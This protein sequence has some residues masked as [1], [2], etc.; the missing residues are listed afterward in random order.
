MDK[1]MKETCIEGVTNHDNPESCVC[2]R[3]A[4]GEALTGAC[5]GSANKPRNKQ[6][7]V[8]TLYI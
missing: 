3:K 1:G 7:T 8:P 4:A 2:H 5:I 6:P